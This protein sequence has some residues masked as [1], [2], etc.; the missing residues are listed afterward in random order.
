MGQA[1]RAPEPVDGSERD[2]LLGWLS[3]HR[4]ALAA[5]CEGVPP[6][7]LISAAVPPSPLSLL[8]LVRHMTEMERVYLVYALGGGELRLV[9]GPY[10]EG[11]PE[12]DFDDLEPGMVEESFDTWRQERQAADELIAGYPSLDGP[13]AGN[14]RSLRWNLTKVIQEYARHNG[15]ADLLRESIDGQTGE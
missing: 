5:K 1:G 9:Y 13:G 6:D 8:G 14:R 2:V 11:A 4:D 7:G 10:E 3:F 15:H 12:G